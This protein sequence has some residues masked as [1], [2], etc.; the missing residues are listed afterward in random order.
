MARFN[1]LEF[2]DDPPQN[3][4]PQKT[5]SVAEKP[6]KRYRN[7]VADWMQEA[8]IQ[9]RMG[10]YEAALRAY[11]RALECERSHV[12]AWGG[13]A[14]ML[15]LLGE[16]RQAEMWTISGLKLFPNN[17]DLLAARA[18]AVCR[19]GNHRE[20]LPYNDT[21]IQGEGTSAYRWSVRGEL[22][23]ASKSSTAG[24]CFDSAEQIDA[25]WLVR[26]EHAKILL[27]YNQPLKALGRAMAAVHTNPEVPFAW[28]VKGMCEYEAGFRSQAIKSLEQALQLDPGC[29]EAKYWLA[30]ARR[31]TGLL[32]RLWNFFRRR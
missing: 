22:M 23:T 11:G 4:Q 29:K 20:A 27:F 19:L 28:L 17:A 13:Q 2:P 9:R 8:N 30:I 15:I 10:Q 21:A 26:T 3:P 32:K 14:Q 6:E 12:A 18:Q 5:E 24:H 1:R 31:D 25:D 16:P 7:N